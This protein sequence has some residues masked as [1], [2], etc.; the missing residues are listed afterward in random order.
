MIHDY[1]SIVRKAEAR[2]GQWAECLTRDPRH[3]GGPLPPAVQA[4]VL[5]LACGAFTLYALE[6]K[7]R[8]IADW[9]WPFAQLDLPEPFTAGRTSSGEALSPWTV[10]L[11]Q[12]WRLVK[13][14]H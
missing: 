14:P 1:A 2:A 4:A 11:H 8:P 10:L 5:D 6:W 3:R 12:A 9:D 13:E 7:H